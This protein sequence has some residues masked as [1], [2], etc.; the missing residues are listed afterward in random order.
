MKAHG[1][2]IEDGRLPGDHLISE[3]AQRTMALGLA[4]ALVDLD[5]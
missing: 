3:N 5:V 1:P 2:L 4:A